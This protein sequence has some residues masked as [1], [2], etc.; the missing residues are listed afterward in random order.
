MKHYYKFKFYINARH[1]VSFNG[2]QSNIHPHTWET[3]V[4]IKM[5][6]GSIINFTEFETLLEKYFINYEGR[7]FND[8]DCFK[9]V[10]P[11]MEN[12]GKKI[13][14]D[15]NQVLTKRGLELFKLEISENPT[16]TYVIEN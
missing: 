14:V 4:Y 13:F 2:V 7:Y 9:K 6:S 11:T 15:L 16:R 5:E 10:N 12:I 8:L 3:V 1:S